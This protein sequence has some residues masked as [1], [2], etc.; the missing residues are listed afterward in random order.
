MKFN[1][2]VKVYGDTDFRG[3]C[4]LESNEQITFINWIR[5][6]HPEIGKVAT[7]IR[8]EGK[9]SYG[10]A[11][12]QKAEGMVKGASD[13]LIPAS[14]AFVC[15]MKRAD[16]TKSVWQDGQ[17]EYLT[18]A[19]ELGAFACVALGHAGAIEGFNEWLSMITTRNG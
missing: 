19:Q 13:I 2:T 18:Q 12:R 6:T 16:H 3:K 17:L 9:R 15:E 1:N 11:A 14:P 10:Q 4:P 8:N 7:H 5:R